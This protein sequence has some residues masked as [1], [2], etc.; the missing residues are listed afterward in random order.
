M[1]KRIL[2]ITPKDSKDTAAVQRGISLAS[3]CN[4][5]LEIIDFCY[6]ELEAIARQT[7]TSQ[8]KLKSEII[9]HKSEILEKT[10]KSLCNSNTDYKNLNIN[11][12]VIWENKIYE[13]IIKKTTDKKYD[14]VIKSGRRSETTFY[15]PTDF[16]LIR[17]CKA[18]VYLLTSKK[19]KKKSL[20]LIALNVED[21]NRAKQ[22]QNIKLLETGRVMADAIGAELDVCFVIRIPEILKELDVVD[23]TTYSKKA[24]EEF[25]PKVI[26]MVEPYGISKE[27]IYREVGKPSS[28]IQK[29]ANKLKA[30]VLIIG[31]KGRKGVSGKLI[32]NTAEQVLKHLYTD[33]IVVN[34]SL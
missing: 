31:M 28:R 13:W 24:R 10:I 6:E 34:R 17:K 7:G 3:L 14:L 27:N 4:A 8:S 18:P 33:M 9:N 22:R 19:W 1:I 26:K 29:I 12:Q 20:V 32:G 30:D 2:V 21:Q 23:T 15:T 11:S 16:H 25:L 5:Q